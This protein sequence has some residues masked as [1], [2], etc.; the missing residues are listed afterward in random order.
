MPSQTSE[1]PCLKGSVTK[2]NMTE[3]HEALII[4]RSPLSLLEIMSQQYVAF[5]KRANAGFIN[6]LLVIIRSDSCIL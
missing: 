2:G 1:L 4:Q 3:D 6:I 5:A